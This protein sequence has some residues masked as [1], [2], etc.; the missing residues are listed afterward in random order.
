MF[1]KD[2]NDEY[3]PR[4]LLDDCLAKY[5]LDK[6]RRTSPDSK[7]V[8]Y[9]RVDEFGDFGLEPRW[10]L[11][12]ISESPAEALSG[13]F[14]E[15]FRLM[16]ESHESAIHLS[17][18]SAFV[19]VS[20]GM[21][22]CQFL[23]TATNEVCEYRDLPEADRLLIAETAEHDL[24]LQVSMNDE[25]PTRIVNIITPT[26]LAADVSIWH[27]DDLFV[28]HHEQWICDGEDTVPQAGGPVDDALMG[29]MTFTT[30]VYEAI[31]NGYPLNVEG[32]MRVARESGDDRTLVA[33]LMRVIATGVEVGLLSDDDF[34]D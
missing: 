12:G 1:E 27:G 10:V 16:R 5:G 34:T 3:R 6:N 18:V 31:R 25:L 8:A 32:L 9:L 19:L 21:G 33:H 28:E 7:C 13:A 22:R 29:T 15:A 23:N 17:R 11:G 26:G 2:D 4:Q 14:T 24:H 30:L 20:H